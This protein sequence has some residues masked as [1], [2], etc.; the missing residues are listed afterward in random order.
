MTVSASSDAP[1]VA[2]LRAGEEAAFAELVQTYSPRMLAVARRFLGNDDDA[3]DAV[4]DAFFSAVKA[5]DKF[6]ESAQLGTWL[7]RIVVNAS[8]MKL[9]TK[10]R[11][12]E[13]PI[14]EL[15][16]AFS[17]D[18]HQ[19]SAASHWPAVTDTAAVD[20]ET[21]ALVRRCI[22]ELPESHRTVLLLRDIEERSTEE[23]AEALG[24]TVSAV[25]TRLHRARLALRELLDPYMRGGA[26]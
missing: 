24:L 19:R 9:R 10:R 11:H 16:P 7:H 21:R 3:G 1:L 23:T 4:Q 26:L 6:E 15:L 2:R 5:L 20:R 14:E 22:E 13:R 8:L 12:P 18:G 25:K 17:N